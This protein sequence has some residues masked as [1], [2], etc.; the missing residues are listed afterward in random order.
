MSG[1]SDG[2]H[3][4]PFYVV[5]GYGAQGGSVGGG[6]MGIGFDASRVVTVAADNR[7]RAYGT[8]GCVCVGPTQTQ[9]SVP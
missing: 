4:G 5:G 9:P 2:V 7:T 1:Y 6:S 3:T 8:L